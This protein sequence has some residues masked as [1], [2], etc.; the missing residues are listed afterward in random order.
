MHLALI[1]VLLAVL[2]A[3]DKKPKDDVIQ[4]KDEAGGGFK[5]G[6]I[7]KV[8]ETG[9][10]MQIKDQ[11]KP[12]RIEFRDMMP[13][14]VYKIK[15][16]RI[17]P[18]DGK[19]HLEL[20]DFCRA[21]GL[22]SVAVK[23]YEAAAAADKT[24]AEPA[25]A[26]I[27][28]TRKEDAGAKFEEAKKF[29][30]QKK[31]AQANE[32]LSDIVNNYADTP[33][34]EDA[35]KEIEKLADAIKKDNEEKKKLLEEKKK[36]EENKTSKGKEELEKALLAQ[37]LDALK[38]AET[39]WAEGLDWE[40][41]ENITNADRTWKGAEAKLLAAKKW[42]ET[43]LKSSDVENLKRG[44]ELEKQADEWLVKVYY[45]LGSL[46]ANQLNFREGRAYLN[47]A[48]KVPHGQEMDRW[49]NETLLELNKLQMRARAAGKGY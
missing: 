8:D 39:A 31:W 35:K 3:Q 4:L 18:A 7:V 13:Y 6:K 44:K 23:E 21:N 20:G 32:L 10:E 15:E 43:V 28:D 30:L 12:V 1:S 22:Y 36:A 9:V 41:K 5:V 2:P 11:P 24:L 25:K 49:I 33:Y 38:D 46:W 45:R 16:A 37:S 48:L 14:S 17:D 47:K 29:S 40:G 19:A 26:K 42:L 34:F 27:A